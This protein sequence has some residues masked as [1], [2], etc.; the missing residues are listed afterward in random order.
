MGARLGVNSY[1]WL[2]DEEP[3]H[4]AQSDEDDRES[5]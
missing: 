2:L 5:D 4:D 3:D 1:I